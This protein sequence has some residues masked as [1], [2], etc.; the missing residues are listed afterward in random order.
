MVFEPPES[1]LAKLTTKTLA[2]NHRSRIVR[3]HAGHRRKIADVAIDHAKQRDDRGLVG[4][5]AVEVA[6]ARKQT[7]LGPA[8]LLEQKLNL[9]GYLPDQGQ[10]RRAKRPNIGVSAAASFAM[11]TDE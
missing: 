10:R 7:E 6:H 11:P 4:G 3:K 8:K 5:D 9:R 2:G 1:V